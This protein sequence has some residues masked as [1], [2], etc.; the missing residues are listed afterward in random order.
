MTDIIVSPMLQCLVAAMFVVLGLLL[1]WALFELSR[2]RTELYTR[3]PV[4]VQADVSETT[5]QAERKRL[6]DKHRQE[7]LDMING[8]L[9]SLS[10][11]G[12]MR[13]HERADHITVQLKQRRDALLE[14]A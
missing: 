14:Q 7:K 3:L 12:S 5:L 13:L 1:C 9:E 11:C 10:S 4:M 6:T 8:L 2:A